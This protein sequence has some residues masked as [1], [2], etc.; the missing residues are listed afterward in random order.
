[1]IEQF[2]K[3]KSKAPIKTKDDLPDKLKKFSHLLTKGNLDDER[4]IE[5]PTAA[6]TFQHSPVIK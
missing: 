1:M 2:N 6:D 5:T 3:V 4:T